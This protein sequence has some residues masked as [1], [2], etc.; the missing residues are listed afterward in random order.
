MASGCPFHVTHRGNQKRTTFETDGDR[1]SYLGML[2]RYAQQF[3]MAVWAYC[4]MPNHVH[5]IVV[6]REHR[7]IALAVG[8][9][10]RVHS[11]LWNQR[12]SV[13]GHLWANR[14]FSTPLD[15][16]HLWAAVRY[17]ELNPV[18]AHLVDRP[19][20]YPWS[21]ARA[22]VSS[23]P[24]EVLDP[25]RPFPGHVANWSEWLSLGLEEELAARIRANTLSGRPTG[26]EGFRRR[27][28]ETG[29]SKQDR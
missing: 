15:E 24:D 14:F 21:S 3:G 18:R 26:N 28:L 27:F 1:A 5:L 2:A 10:H 16:V 12:Q 22:H 7:S 29:A 20:D 6:G 25:A 17:V 9:A 8:N 13:T 11:R 23:G 4:L 19:W